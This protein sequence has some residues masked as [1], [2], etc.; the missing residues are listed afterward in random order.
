MRE[1]TEKYLL[2]A[3]ITNILCGTLRRHVES[4]DIAESVLNISGFILANSLT[5]N[6][7][8]NIEGIDRCVE[9]ARKHPGGPAMGFRV[10]FWQEIDN[11]MMSHLFTHFSQF[12]RFAIVC[13]HANS[14]ILAISSSPLIEAATPNPAKTWLLGEAGIIKY[15]VDEAHDVIVDY[16]IIFDG[17]F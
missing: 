13:A 11:P 4:A 12:V 16:E 10:D 15:I 8:P 14:T 6:G 1:A 9:E 5:L 3:G 7:V 2:N 17:Y